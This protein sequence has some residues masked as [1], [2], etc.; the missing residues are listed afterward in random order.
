MDDARLEKMLSDISEGRISVSQGMEALKQMPFED[1]GCACIDHHR[2]FRKGFPE[3]IYSPGKSC[4]QLVTIIRTL[5]KDGGPVLATRVSDEQAEVVVKEVEGVIF[6]PVPRALTWQEKEITT[7]D[8][9]GV[10]LVITAGT[11][12]IPVAEEAVLTLRLMGNR[13]E[14]MY[15]AGVAG[16]HRLFAGMD[17]IRKAGVI[18]VAAGMDG[19]LPSIVGGI[20][21]APVIALPVSSGYGASFQGVAALLSMLNS[22]ATGVA[23]VN[24]DNGFGA[25]AMA[26]M[27]LGS[28]KTECS[29]K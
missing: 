23:V 5:I 2:R 13:V 17:R 14:K 24:I 7:E 1:I 18:I 25:G 12:D 19:A 11:A 29:M 8:D 9:A 22:C 27:I 16:I 3:V 15:D 28:S 4:E 6:H 10:V 26:S 20:S 21:N